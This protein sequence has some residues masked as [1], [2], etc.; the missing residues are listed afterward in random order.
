[1]LHIYG[2]M[3][4]MYLGSE[5]HRY[6]AR[7]NGKTHP[8]DDIYLKDTPFSKEH[9]PCPFD[10]PLE[11]AR[12]VIC[13]ANPNYPDEV[14][15]VDDYNLVIQEQRSGEEDLPKAWDYYYEPRIAKP[16]NAEMEQLRSIVSVFNVC[17]YASKKM[18]G[19]E[20]R[21]AAGLPSVWQA[22]KYLREVLIPRAQTGNVYLV[23]MRK[24]F[25]WGITEGLTRPTLKV[26]RGHELHGGLPIGVGQEIHEWLLKK[27]LITAGK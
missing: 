24:H 14:G 27:K 6:W 3:R 19:L 20:Q 15:Q 25:L 26:V 4:R 8:D 1:M 22:Q 7:C 5:F 9:L 12:V 13:L 23:F 16:I 18:D 11:K 21:I 17:P 10:G 2:R